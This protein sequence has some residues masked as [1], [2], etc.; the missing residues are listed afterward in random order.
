MIT[1]TDTLEQRLDAAQRL[2]DLPRAAL[3]DRLALTLGLQ[4]LLRE[5]R[6]LR[7]RDD[8]AA[9]AELAR[10]RHRGGDRARSAPVPSVVLRT[11]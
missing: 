1:T 5:E 9:R 6:S 7:R 11:A 10:P 2:Q 8:R 3:A 4:L